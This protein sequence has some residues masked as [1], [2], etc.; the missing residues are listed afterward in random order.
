MWTPHIHEPQF[1]EAIISPHR[2]ARLEKDGPCE[3]PTLADLKGNQRSKGHVAFSD[4]LK[5][6]AAYLDFE[7]HL[8]AW[9]QEELLQ[10]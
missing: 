3:L 10:L 6:Y 9:P 7:L 2:N 8:H 4:C 1:W 5:C